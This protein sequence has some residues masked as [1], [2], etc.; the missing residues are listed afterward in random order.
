MLPTVVEPLREE[1]NH[2]RAAAVTLAT[3]GDLKGAVKE[4]RAFHHRLC[5]VQVLDPACGSGNFLYVTLEHLKRLEGEVLALIESFGENMRLD[6][7]G[8]TVDPHQFLGLEVNPRAAAIAELVLWIGYLQWHHRNRGATEWPQP[9]LRAFKNIECRDAVLAYDC[10]DV[11]TAEMAEAEPRTPGLP[12]NW[13]EFIDKR[14][15]VICLWDQV[16]EVVDPVSGRKLAD[17]S[18]VVPLR[19][20]RNARPAVWPRTDFIVGNPPFIGNK[21]MRRDLGDGYVATIRNIRK[22]VPGSANFVMFWW[23]QAARLLRTGAIQRFGLIT[24]NAITQIQSGKIVQEHLDSAEMS[25]AFS[26][27]DHPW[28]D[29]TDGAAVRISMSVGQSGVRD[30]VC[31]EIMNETPLAD[32]SS[33]VTLRETVGLIHA[34]LRV[35]LNLRQAKPLRSNLGVCWQGVKLVGDGFQISPEQRELFIRK[36]GESEQKLPEYWTGKDFTDGRKLRYV[37][38][39]FGLTA[40]QSRSNFPALFDYLATHVKPA[41]DKNRD[42]GFRE[43]WWVFGR[44]RPD[45]R[46]ALAGLDRYIATSEVAEHRV[47]QFLP[48]PGSLID[49]GMIAVASGDAFVLGVLSCRIHVVWV[50]KGGGALEDRP[51][52]NNEVCFDNFPFPECTEKQ[53]DRIR[54]LAED[55]DLLRKRVLTKCGVGLTELYNVLEKAKAGMQLAS[56]ER[57]LFDQAMVS[58]LRELHDRLDA[59]VADAY[60]W[61]WPMEDDTILERIVDLSHLRVSDEKKGLVRWLRPEYQ[62]PLFSNDR[63]TDF[64]LVAEPQA[65]LHPTKKRRVPGHTKASWPNSLADRVRAVEA[66]LAAEEKPATST[67][68]AAK[69]SRAKAADVEEILQ[70]LVTLGRARLGD[71]K[72]TFVH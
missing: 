41:R 48:W 32:G 50:L 40:E 18:A 11:V 2:V 1:W 34:R 16:T 23:D 31:R 12:E 45:L 65:M 30:G 29:S 38:D 52:Y 5:A 70:T 26:I 71:V 46:R 37:I 55:L 59:A 60:G 4:A 3:R 28:V 35:G 42:R 36:D 13:R 43:K 15:G 6:L 61:Q 25:L 69:F 58:T 14:T 51:R 54:A 72:N 47:F 66:A 53:K 7:G 21:R 39:L 67:D 22:E 64:G 56:K 49:G 19:R 63:Q 33:E 27:P 24:T 9:V 44:P 10:E 17:T 57:L 62:V 20:Y 68:L 8:E